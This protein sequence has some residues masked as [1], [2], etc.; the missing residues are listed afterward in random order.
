MRTVFDF[1]LHVFII[2]HIFLKFTSLCLEN[3]GFD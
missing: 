3:G 2:G 1:V